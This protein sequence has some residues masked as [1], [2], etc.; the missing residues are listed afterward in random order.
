MCIYN[1]YYQIFLIWYWQCY[2]LY[3]NRKCNF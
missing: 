2:R 3:F 1:S